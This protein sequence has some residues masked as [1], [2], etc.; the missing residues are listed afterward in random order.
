MMHL[1]ATF[2]WKEHS[3][4]RQIP[5]ADGFVRDRDPPLGEEIFDISETQAEAVIEPDG[6][7]DDFGRESVSVIAGRRVIHR[8]TL[9]AA[10]ST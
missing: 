7:T 8:P 10:A 5:L 4:L 9:P 2:P 3:G 1:D 6:V